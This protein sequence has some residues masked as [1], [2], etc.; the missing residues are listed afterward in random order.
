MWTPDSSLD[1]CRIGSCNIDRT[2]ST[3]L[4]GQISS[5]RLTLQGDVAWTKVATSPVDVVWTKEVAWL[6]SQAD[7]VW[8]EVAT[9][10]VNVVWTKVVWNTSMQ[11]F[12]SIEQISQADV[13][14]VEMPS[15]E[16]GN[17]NKRGG[18]KF[19]LPN[20]SSACCLPFDIASIWV[21]LFQAYAAEATPQALPTV[22]L[23]LRLPTL[24]CTWLPCLT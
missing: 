11:S 14:P 20:I 15:L 17:W 23:S 2:L 3:R 24:D 9:S 21:G 22:L 4:S 7:G 8:T 1:G 13:V 19:N 12:S 16:W 6:P 18:V 10:P 5:A